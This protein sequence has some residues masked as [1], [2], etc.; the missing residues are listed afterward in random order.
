MYYLLH[1][2][3]IY[4]LYYF[5]ILILLYYLLV[6]FITYKQYFYYKLTIQKLSPI[7]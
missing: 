1:Y 6:L 7:S 2:L 3:F 5:I 4:Y